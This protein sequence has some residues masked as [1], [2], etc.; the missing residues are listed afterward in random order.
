VRLIVLHIC[1]FALLCVGCAQ[2]PIDRT[3]SH[4]VILVHGVAGDN[5]S[6][7]AL[8]DETETSIPH[9][10]VE[11]FQWGTPVFLV[12]F[13]NE[14]VHN[15]A[16]IKLADRIR[17]HHQDHQQATVDLVGHS[18]GG[19]VVLGAIKRLPPGVNVNRV[20][21]LHASVS[22][23]YEL[24][25]VMN[26]SNQVVNFYS[27]QDVTFLKWRVSTFGGYDRK[28]EPAAGHVGFST[29]SQRLVQIQYD[30]DWKTLGHD[31]GH[32]GPL[33]GEFVKNHVVPLLRR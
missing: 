9:A 28:K 1:M 21:L 23:G 22:P 15:H 33:S 16:E 12:N 26:H 13:S 27:E 3:S 14:N 7:N 32:F 25:E 20:I 10:R 5:S 6:Y 31:G 8:L 17:R 19:G 30:P 11:R 4:L 24:Q 18:A 29:A 2:A